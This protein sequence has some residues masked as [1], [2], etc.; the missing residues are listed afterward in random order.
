M[1]LQCGKFQPVYFP[2]CT[3]SCHIRVMT[4]TY[5]NEMQAISPADH[6]ASKHSVTIHGSRT[7][8]VGRCFH[9]KFVAV[10]QIIWAS[11]GGRSPKN[12]GDAGIPP[13]WDGGRLRSLET[14]FSL[15]CRF[16]CSFLHICWNELATWHGYQPSQ[17][18]Q[19]A[20]WVGTCFWGVFHARV[21]RGGDPSSPKILDLLP[22]RQYSN[23]AWR[24][25]CTWGKIFTRSTMNA[26]ARSICGS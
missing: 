2:E 16:I 12:S 1:G 17:V 14:Y 10:G 24:S 18:V 6:Y 20:R 26:D 23:F 8:F 11:V 4:I 3:S 13:L 19:L 7:N 21:P 25:N 15:T 5:A 9:T 22:A